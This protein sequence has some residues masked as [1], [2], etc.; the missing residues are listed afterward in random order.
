MAWDWYP[1][2]EVD[3]VM[4]KD[5]PDEV[6]TVDIGDGDEEIRFIQGFTVGLIFRGALF[7]PNMNDRNPFVLVDESLGAMI[8]EGQYW[9]G[10]NR[11]D[12]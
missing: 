5:T 9:V 4:E 6:L 12:E 2:K 3:A 7:F 10:I 8:H 11:G 1:I